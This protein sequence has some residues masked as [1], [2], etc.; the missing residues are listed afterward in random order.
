MRKYEQRELQIQLE[1]CRYVALKYPKAVFSS[2]LSGLELPKKIVKLILKLRSE[3]GFLDFQMFEPNDRYSALFIEIKAEGNSPFRKDNGLLRK[4]STGHLQEQQAMIFKLRKRGYFALFGI[5][6]DECRY[7]VD[8]YMKTH[9][10][11]NKSS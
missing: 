11:F 4:D 7:I 10:C 1:L 3:N 9:P 8:D 5:G 2:D 6:L